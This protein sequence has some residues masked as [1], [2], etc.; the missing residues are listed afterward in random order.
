[1][2]TTGLVGA[3]GWPGTRGQAV[4]ADDASHCASEWH[5]KVIEIELRGCET[6]SR[7]DR[8]RL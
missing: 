2:L 5:E 4:G 6:R 7:G 8:R 3:I 1:M